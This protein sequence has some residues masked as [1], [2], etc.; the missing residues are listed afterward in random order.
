MKKFKT[1]LWML[2]LSYLITWHWVL[3]QPY[4]SPMFERCYVI[5][6][7]FLIALH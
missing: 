6:Y 4:N 7:F 2:R 5:S 1:K 3:A